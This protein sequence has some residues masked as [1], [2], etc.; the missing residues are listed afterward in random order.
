MPSPVAHSVTAWPEALGLRNESV[1]A[2]DGARLR[3][4]VGGSATARPVVLLHGAPQFSYTW[5]RVAS[6]LQDRYRLVIPDLR[7]Y[8]ASDVSPNGD[9]GLDRL[10]AD[11]D[12]V[13]RFAGRG[14]DEPVL[15]VAHDWGGPIAWRYLEREPGRVRHLVAVNAPHLAA[16]VG[17][18]GHA[19]Q[20]LRSWYI[21]FFQL[22]F[23]ERII[24]RGDASFFLWMMRASSPKGTFSDEDLEIYRAALRPRERIE[25]VLAF[26]RDA[27][28][29]HIPGVVARRSFRL[30]SPLIHTPATIVWGDGDQALAPTHPDAVRRWATH[31]EV[32]RLPG[33]SHWVPEERPDEVVRA[34]VD[35]DAGS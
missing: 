25:A 15:L 16:F 21:G 22:P 20:A 17:E 10:V 3:V 5:R 11:L 14:T 1:T 12:E 28:R 23:A 8:G 24:E 32:R 35:G 19:R 2:S 13:V 27:W 34:L 6:L 9:Y 7:G 29:R 30:D 26:Y 33:V 31:L 18:L 4:V